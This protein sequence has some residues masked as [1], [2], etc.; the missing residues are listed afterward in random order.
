MNNQPNFY[1]VVIVGA[2]LSGIGAAYHIQT[3]C[4]RHTYTILEAR[5]SLGGTWDLFKYP[6]IRSDSDMYT[7]GFSFYP[8][9]NPKAIADGDSILQYIHE[10]ADEFGIRERIQFNQKV[11]KAEWSSKSQKW[12]LEIE[13]TL[14][15]QSTIIECSFLMMCSGYYDYTAGYQPQFP[16]Q[17]AYQGIFFHPQKWDTALDY[18]DKEIVIIGSGATAITLLPELAKKAKRVT[19]LQRS[20]T[21]IMNLPSEDAVANFFKKVLPASIAHKISRWKNIIIGIIFYKVCRKYPNFIKKLLTNH[22][23]KQL[24][25]RFKAADFEPKYRPWDQRLCLVPDNDLFIAMQQGKADIITDHIES[26]ESQGILLKS[27]KSLKADIIVSATGLKIQ[28]FGGMKILKDGVELHTAQVHAYRGV[29]FSDVP[30]FAVSIGYTNASWTLKCDL[31]AHFVTKVLNYMQKK[32][33]KVCTPRFDHE[34]LHT[35]R[36]LDF[37]AGYI[38]RAADVLPKQGSKK[39][40]KVYQNYL[41]DF[42]SLK[43]SSAK[44]KYLEYVK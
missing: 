34:H 12:T 16:N 23:K 27:G 3:K 4:P 20:P 40:W 28:L 33:F 15:T 41:K 32:G 25:E 29:M 21:Y 13:S 19:M 35:E 1:D 10:T 26:F 9:K 31:N 5:G 37:D 22:I 38:L 36:L 7:F 2:G 18:T 42:F 11:L 39:P 43:Y 24:G 14:S 44:D 8:W 6:G 30:N 17:S